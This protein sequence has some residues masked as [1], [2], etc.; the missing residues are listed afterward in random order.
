MSTVE[1]LASVDIVALRLAPDA[2]HLQVLLHRR[3]REPHAGQWALPG[4]IVNGRTPDTSLEDA[5]SRALCEKARVQPCYMEQ[6]G[7]EGNAF[8]DPRGWSLSTYY[9]ALLDP[10]QAVEGEQLAFFDLDSVL[11]RKALLPFDHNLLVERARE[12]L[13]A[14]TVYSS[15]PLYLLA[16]KFTVQDAL[17]AVQACL[18]QGVNGTSVRKRLERL[19]ELG[20]VRDTGE[21]HQPKLGRPQQLYEYTPRGQ[22][23]FMFDRSLLPEGA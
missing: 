13:A 17:G 1:V 18:G 2:Q 11:G 5:A 15:L 23:A 21:K 3:E 12:R 7:T 9:L 10:A 8:R 19:R 22:Q 4:V 16:Q 14:K 20:W 6:V